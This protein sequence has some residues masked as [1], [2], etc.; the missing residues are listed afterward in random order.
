MKNTIRTT[1]KG[2]FFLLMTVV[3]LRPV[4]VDVSNNGQTLGKG[5][6]S[7][8]AIPTYSSRVPLSGFEFSKGFVSLS[9]LKFIPKESFSFVSLTPQYAKSYLS[10]DSGPSWAHPVVSPFPT[11]RSFH[12]LRI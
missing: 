6:C 12:I 4:M 2:V 9:S 1:F 11:C 10:Q 3:A 8:S 7:S 5:F